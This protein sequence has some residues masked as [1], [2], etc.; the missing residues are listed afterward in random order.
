MRNLRNYWNKEKCFNEALKYKTRKEFYVQ[1]GRS[2]EVLRKN[3]WLKDACSHMKI[4]YETKFK[5]S[6]EKCGKL[7]LK[8]KH[9]KEFQKDN[10]NAYYSAMH[11]G[12]LDEICQHM[13]YKKLP[14][15]FLKCH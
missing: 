3:G 13:Q 4:P 5:W 1:S 8:Y 2:Y 7:A 12:W 10:K 9:R 15:I 14:N 11:N 6:K